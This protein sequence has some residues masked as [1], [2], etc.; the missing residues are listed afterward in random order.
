MA[1]YG[2][3]IVGVGGWIRVLLAET[4]R[5]PSAL[6]FGYVRLRHGFGVAVVLHLINNI[7]PFLLVSGVGV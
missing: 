3:D 4:A 7:L 5:I 2:S 6:M 1:N